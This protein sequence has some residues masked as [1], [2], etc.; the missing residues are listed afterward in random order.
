[1]VNKTNAITSAILIAGW[2]CSF[3]GRASGG[4]LAYESWVYWGNIGEAVNYLCAAIAFYR[5]AHAMG[6]RLLCEYAVIM[7]GIQ[8]LYTALSVPLRYNPSQ[9]LFAVLITALYVKYGRQERKIRNSRL[10]K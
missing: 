5:V 8:L 9:Y 7:Y 10:I 1:M 6:L 2:L 4:W 3:M